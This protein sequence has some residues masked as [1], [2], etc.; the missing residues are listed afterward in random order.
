MQQPQG[1]LLIDLD[2]ARRK[3]RVQMLEKAG[4]EVRL[5]NDWIKA[6][7]LDH[8]GD[9]DLVIIALHERDLKQAAAYSDRLTKSK[10]TLPILLL[11]DTG[12]FAPK[13]TLSKSLETGDPVELMRRVASM[14]AGSTHIHELSV[15]ASDD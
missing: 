1:I 4:Y 6:E 7:D 3:T 2:D 14:L 8:E 10:P 5:R 11:T 12:V 9:F 15:T 13:G